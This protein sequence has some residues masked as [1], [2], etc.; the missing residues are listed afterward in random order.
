MVDKGHVTKNEE[1][2]LQK[3]E[4]IL[5]QYK[6]KLNTNPFIPDNIVT[7]TGDKQ[8]SKTDQTAVEKFS[9]DISSVLNALYD[10]PSNI[11]WGRYILETVKQDDRYIS[12]C[13]LLLSIAFLISVV[14]K[15]K[16]QAINHKNLNHKL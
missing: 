15:S 6:S 11:T 12:V 5:Q 10:K 14:K 3:S 16:S 13:F 8:P 1:S 4:P 2:G 9:H 7:V